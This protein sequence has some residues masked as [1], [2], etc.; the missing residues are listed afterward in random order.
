MKSDLESFPYGFISNRE[1]NKICTIEN[2]ENKNEIY[3]EVVTF[4]A[5]S[6]EAG[7]LP[8]YLEVLV[9]LK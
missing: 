2:K 8:G 6:L 3:A 1:L 4:V 7:G 9:S 5:S